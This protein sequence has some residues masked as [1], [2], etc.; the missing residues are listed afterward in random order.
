MRKNEAFSGG[1]FIPV[2]C[3]L[4]TFAFIRKKGQRQVLAAVNRWCEE[5]S[6]PLP[7]GFESAKLTGGRIS[8]GRL[9]IPAYGFALLEK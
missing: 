8:D 9:F 7:E 4:G 6:I 5:E 1:K 3:E 2:W